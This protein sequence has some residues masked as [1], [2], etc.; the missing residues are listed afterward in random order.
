MYEGFS[1][2]SVVKNLP[3]KQEMLGLIPALGRSPGEGNGNVFQ[4]SCLGSPMDKE[5]W[6][7]T[8]HESQRV[9]HNLA[10]KQQQM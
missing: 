10:P 2:D 6:Q 3:A 9:R 4:D 7:A 8:V 1:G 5:A